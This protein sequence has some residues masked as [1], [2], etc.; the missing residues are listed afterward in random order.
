[1]EAYQWYSTILHSMLKMKNLY[2]IMEDL[3]LP[4]SSALCTRYLQLG[5]IM[6]KEATVRLAMELISL[7]GMDK[8]MK[9]GAGAVVL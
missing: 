6:R 5:L 8:I 2:E 1:M 7:M 4:L 9:M 3:F